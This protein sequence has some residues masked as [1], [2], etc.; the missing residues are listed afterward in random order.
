MFRKKVCPNCGEKIKEDWEFCPHCGE[1]VGTETTIEREMMAPF[2]SI[3]DDIDKEFERID[4]MFGLDSFKFPELVKRG[5][6]GGS[7]S[8]TVQSGTGMKPKVEIK[9]SGDYRKLEPE[10]KRKLGIKPGVEE[11]EEK[12]EKKKREIRLP[13]VTEEPETEIQ[14]IGNK[15]IVSIKLPDVKDEDDIEIKRL[16]QSIE[17]KAFV[18]DKAYFKLIPIP[19]NATVSKKFR[20]GVL[21]IEIER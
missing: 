8:I 12:V 17:V 1:K 5:G 10:L 4:K 9:T 13:K 16:G 11:V 7:I 19:P 3:F 20:D 15:Q 2:R 18:D 6:R 21:R 14:T